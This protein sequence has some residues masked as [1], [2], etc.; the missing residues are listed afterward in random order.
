MSYLINI[1]R[2][3]NLRYLI[4]D[5]RTYCDQ[6]G[7][8]ALDPAFTNFV[9][10]FAHHDILIGTNS[11]RRGYRA[12]VTDLIAGEE[13]D[14]LYFDNEEMARQDAVHKG[15]EILHSRNNR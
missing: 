11:D 5:Y 3:P 2:N 12:F 7:L 4:N 15:F 14:Q 13:R 9:R 8:S 10:F 1:N 6:E